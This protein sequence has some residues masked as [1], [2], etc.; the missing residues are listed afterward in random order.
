[1]LPFIAL[2]ALLI[3]EP[4]T[5]QTNPACGLL[6]GQEISAIIG[7]GAKTIPVTA[8]PN[9]GSCMYQ[10]GDKMVTILVAKQQ[11][12]ESA[13]SLW[14]SKKRIAAGHDVEGWPSKA[15][16]GSAGTVPIVGLTKG[17]TFIEVKVIDAKQTLADL[18]PKVRTAM[19]GV[20]T[21]M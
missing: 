3:A 7:A 15:Y 10:N 13:V 20:A 5:Q 21:R 17:M 18:A 2:L 8:S 19:K 1:M 6:T 9:G 12:A 4:P 11:T 14:T 16:E